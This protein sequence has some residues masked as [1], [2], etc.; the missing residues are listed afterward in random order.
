MNFLVFSDRLA[1]T[2]N[3]G[4]SAVEIEIPMTPEILKQ[5]IRNLRALLYQHTQ[6]LTYQLT[7]LCIDYEIDSEDSTPLFQNLAWLAGHCRDEAAFP[8][9]HY[10]Q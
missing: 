1:D 7:D 8:T 3:F 5:E 10:M 2:P 4:D 6:V 9:E